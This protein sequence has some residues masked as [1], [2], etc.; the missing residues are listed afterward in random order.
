MKFFTSVD[1]GIE[2]IYSR[3]E[4]ESSGYV[5]IDFWRDIRIPYVNL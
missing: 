3:M 2:N 1:I 5:G 4:L